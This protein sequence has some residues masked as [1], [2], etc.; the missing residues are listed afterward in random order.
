MNVPL[1]RAVASGG[2]RGAAAPPGPVEPDKSSLWMDLV[3]LYLV[4]LVIATCNCSPFSYSRLIFRRHLSLQALKIIFW[5]LQILKFSGGGYPQPPY[6]ARANARAFGTRGNAP[7]PSQLQKTYNHGQTSWD[8]YAFL[9][10]F[11]IRTGPTP[12]LTPQTML[13]ACIQNFFPSFNFV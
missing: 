7:L 8:T 13:D 10:R 5:S 11:P 4:I 9:G 2:T 3:S 12:P 6:N 1:S